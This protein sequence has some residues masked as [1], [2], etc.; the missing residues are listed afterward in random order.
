MN[1]TY[2]VWLIIEE[3]EEAKN[4]GEKVDKPLEL[5]AFQS[6]EEA[7]IFCQELAQRFSARATGEVELLEEILT[8]DQFSAG[9]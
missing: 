6:I 5:A 4:R 2:K 9:D 7:Q 1:R 3:I 8:P